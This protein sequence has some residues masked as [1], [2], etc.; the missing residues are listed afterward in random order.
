M[1]IIEMCKDVIGWVPFFMGSRISDVS[2][3]AQKF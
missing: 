2:F 3:C 1:K